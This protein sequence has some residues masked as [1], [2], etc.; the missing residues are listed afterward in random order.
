MVTMN[1]V[2]FLMFSFLSLLPLSL[3]APTS[4]PSTNPSAALEP[5][6]IYEYPKGTWLENL[7]IR[8]SDGNAL[9][10]ILS[11]SAEVYLISTTDSSPPIHVASIPNVLGTLGIVEL[12]RDIFYVVAGNWSA[13]TLQNAPG[14]Y[15]IW[16]ID[17]RSPFTEL[18][19]VADLPDAAFLNGLAVSNPVRGLL[20][21]AD[22]G[23][24]VV[25]AVNAFNGSVSVAINDTT[26]D[27]TPDAAP[28]LGINSVV[29]KDEYLYYANTNRATFN[30]IPIDV[31]TGTPTG[32]AQTLLQSDTSTIFPDDFTFDFAGNAW[33]TADILSELDFLGGAGNDP[34]PDAKVAVEVVAGNPAASK[35]AGWTAAKFGTS[36]EDVQRG[37]LYVTTNGGPLNYLYK[38]WTDGGMLVRLDTVDLGVYL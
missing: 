14:T 34:S 18:N 5:Q 25:W 22:S 38:N 33:L 31:L 6:I 11:P 4:A 10:T 13:S 3:S 32:S 24:G 17:M 28:P 30:R 21:A 35:V 16:S 27:P 36:L 15:S 9:V 26:M 23:L 20:L 19:K 8:Q 29:V 7:V 37:S 12:A 2:H 1:I